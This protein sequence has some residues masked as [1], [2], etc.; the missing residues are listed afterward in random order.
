MKCF[1]LSFVLLAS[2][3]YARTVFSAVSVNG[4]DQGHAVGVRVPASNAAITDITSN[5]IICNTGFIQPVSQ[6]VI[7]VPAGSQ[8]TAQFH[9][10]SAGYVG[11]DPADP[12]DPTN[13]GP[14]MAYLAA[15]PSATQSNWFKIFESGYDTTTRQW[16]SDK[17]FINGGNATFTIPSCLKAGQYLLRAEAIALQNAASYPG[18]QFYMSCAQLSITGTGTTSPSTVSFPGAY[19]PTDPGIVVSG[20]YGVTSY[21][22]PGPAV[23]SC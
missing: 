2:S 6:A 17:L 9:H 19:K 16:G 8:V 22:A 15:V 13:K 21:R 5:D 12:L 18:A 20:I 3:A 11:P 1:L 7:T 10:T 14:V 23:F 4:V